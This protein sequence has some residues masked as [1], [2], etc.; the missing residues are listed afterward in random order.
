MNK[1]DWLKLS[2]ILEEPF[3]SY[4]ERAMPRR[5]LRVTESTR[6]VFPERGPSFAFSG[7]ESLMPPAA[8]EGAIW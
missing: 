7:C 1:S 6:G 8:S 3:A 4:L 2:A 5:Q